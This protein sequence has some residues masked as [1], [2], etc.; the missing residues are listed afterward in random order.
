MEFN[1]VS[2]GV[3][4]GGL[5][6]SSEIKVLIC[7]ILKSVKEPVPAS[8]LCEILNYEGLANAF[9]VSDNIENLLN[10]NHIVCVNKDEDT[11]TT[12]DSGNSIAET[13]K[14]SV[15]LSVRE[16]ACLATLKMLSRI[17]NTKETDIAITREGENTFITCSALDGNSTV[18][19]VKLLVTDENQAI[20]IKNK[21]LDDPSAIYSKLIDLFTE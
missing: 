11:Y 1:A 12:T 18:M 19:S 5:V 16:K 21:F 8:N 15:P 10:N 2:A 3:A 14:A 9:E 13:L 4:P 6:S 7:Y 20:S 17:R